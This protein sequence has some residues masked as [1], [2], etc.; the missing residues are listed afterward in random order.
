MGQYKN[1]IVKRGDYGSHVV[2]IQKALKKA[3]FWPSWVRFSKNF[4]PTTD[5]YVRKFQ[6]HFGVIVDGKVGATT[7]GLLAI[8]FDTTTV[9]E[10]DEKYKDVVIIGSVFPDKPIKKNVRIR[11]NKEIV[12]EYLPSMEIV[13]NSQPKGFKLLITIMAYKE[14][15]RKGTRSYK[16]NN[17]GNI[18]N[19]DAGANKHNGTLSDGVRL[20]KDYINRIVKGEHSA[21]PMGKR[22]LIKPYY[23]PEIAKH[24]KLYGMS[25]YVPGYDFVFDGQLDQF[26]KIY[27]TGSRAGNSYLSI[28]ISYFAKNGITI[29]AQSKIQ[30]II[31]LK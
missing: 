25:P 22:K 9:T 3:G 7:F 2:D 12:N 29:T 20:Q 8:A 13:M 31:K 16:T 15:F 30:D 21:Y 18:G 6:S 19:N 1:I 4:G 26:V 28:I 10:F 14:G 5:K 23:S 24:S 11:L 27:A 17:P